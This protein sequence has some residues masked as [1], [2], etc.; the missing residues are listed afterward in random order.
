MASQHPAA[1]SFDVW[2]LGHFHLL[3]FHKQNELTFV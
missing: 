1:G 3:L 2:Q